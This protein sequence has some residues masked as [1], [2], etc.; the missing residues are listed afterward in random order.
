MLAHMV[1]AIEALAEGCPRVAQMECDSIRETIFWDVP[2][3]S[4]EHDLK[5]S[6]YGGDQQGASIGP[7]DADAQTETSETAEAGEAL[8][9]NVGDAERQSMDERRNPFVIALGISMGRLIE[10]LTNNKCWLCQKTPVIAR[11]ILCSECE[12]NAP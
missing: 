3:E 4:I 9:G 2:N 7:S 10:S 8:H 12:N 5:G 6:D 11:G 1:L